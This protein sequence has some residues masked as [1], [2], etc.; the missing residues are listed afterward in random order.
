MEKEIIALTLGL[1]IAYVLFKLINEK[2]KNST[3]LYSNL[4]TNEKYKVKGQW[5]R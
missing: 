3:E 4:L 2:Q 5:N 1:I